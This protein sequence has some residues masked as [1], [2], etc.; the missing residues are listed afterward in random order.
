MQDNIPTP[1]PDSVSQ[2]AWDSSQLHLRPWLDDIA[3]WL[4]AQHS[5][6]SPIIEFG[7]VL[8]SQGSVAAFNLEHALY[9]RSRLL[10]AHSFDNPS[11]RNPIF[12]AQGTAS[13][14]NLQATSRQ[15]R[16]QAQSAAASTATSTG[17]PAAS[18]GPVSSASGLPP[19][20]ADEAKRYI[21]APEL[22][23]ATDRKMMSHILQTITCSA[24]RR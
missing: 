23:E 8:T 14:Q 4:P 20:T 11:P 21:V 16:S 19:L 12:A 17:A 15:T 7:Y 13:S 10:V 22:I 9:C 6:Y 18:G 24:A 5:N 3:A 1:D 2:P